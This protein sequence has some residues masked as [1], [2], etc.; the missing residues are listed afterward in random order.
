LTRGARSALHLSP[1]LTK[2]AAKVAASA[3]GTFTLSYVLQ[4]LSGHALWVPPQLRVIIEVFTTMLGTT[5]F[6]LFLRKS[7][8]L[9]ERRRSLWK[10][11]AW[12]VAALAFFV[13][14]LW[15]RAECV[16]S[17]DPADWR[18]DKE[19]SD[20]AALP[21]FVDVEHGEVYVPLR[22]LPDQEA[23]IAALG[24][25]DGEGVGGLQ[26]LL[27]QEPD[28]LFDWLRVSLRTQLWQT[29]AVFLCV[30]LAI[31][32]CAALATACAGARRE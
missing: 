13:V 22:F 12:I 21:S 18:V 2:G 27:Q 3:T 30:H 24:R 28:R 9:A 16:I 5:L 31:I 14:S 10:A 7:R 25:A 19:P 6:L 32:A 1:E 29:S 26:L 17:W 4:Q 20:L 8:N 15:L 11:L 23:Y